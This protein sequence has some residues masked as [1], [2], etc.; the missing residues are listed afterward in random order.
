MQAT[1]EL[2]I[3][4]MSPLLPPR[5]LKAALPMTEAAHHTVWQAA[6][7]SSISCAGRTAGSW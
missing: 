7:P 2:P 3:R 5:A 6:L 4:A 1:Q